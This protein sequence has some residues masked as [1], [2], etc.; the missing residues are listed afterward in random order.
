M[1][2]ALIEAMMCGC[3]PV[4]TNCPTGPKEIIKNNDYG[5]LVPVGNPEM[6]A[7]DL[8]SAIEKPIDKQKLDEAIKPFEEE[9]VIKQH[10]KM[11]K[12]LEIKDIQ[13]M[14]Y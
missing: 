5:Y 1:P 14:L 12:I 3:T 2:N 9:N 4:S 11:L 13:W 8:E 6:M 10:L 7:K